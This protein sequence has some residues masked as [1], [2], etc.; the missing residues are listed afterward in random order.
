[1]LKILDV[2]LA[3][4]ILIDGMAV[5]VQVDSETQIMKVY[6]VLKKK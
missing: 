5:H 1:M 4:R 3:N 2:S 6:L